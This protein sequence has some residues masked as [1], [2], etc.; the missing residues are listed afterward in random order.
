MTKGFETLSKNEG[1]EKN[2]SLSESPELAKVKGLFEQYEKEMRY[3]RNFS[4]HT[5]KGCWRVFNRWLKYARSARLAEAV[6]TENNLSQFVIW[7]REAGLNTTTCNIS[8]VAFN[9]FLTW[10]KEKNRVPSVISKEE[11]AS[12]GATGRSPVICE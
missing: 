2:L 4:G 11:I 7:M 6:P 12:V 3:L 9:S 8:I 1:I 5:L 10:L